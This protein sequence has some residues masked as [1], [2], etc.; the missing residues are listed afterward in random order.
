MDDVFTAAEVGRMRQAMLLGTA[1]VTIPMPAALTATLAGSETETGLALLVLV[2]QRQRFE[3]PQTATAEVVEAATRLHQ[4]PLPILPENA[5]RLFRRL[6]TSVEK[7]LAGGVV[8]AARRRL[9]L[10]GY[11]PHPFDLPS[12]VA[13]LDATADVLTLSERAYLA[14]IETRPETSAPRL[15]DEEITA[16]TWLEFPKAQRRTF[17]RK[18]RA[19]D[20][21]AGRLL[22]EQC[23]A[24][25]QAAMRSELLA[26][27]ATG[28]GTADV[29]FL[30]SLAKDRAES[31][32]SIATRL[33]SQVRGNAAHSTRL[34]EAAKCFERS[35]KLKSA[36]AK[37]GLADAG[38]NFA[39][40]KAGSARERATALERLFD[41]IGL[42]DLVSA[43]GTDSAA[44]L[45][46][47]PAD[48]VVA[49]HLLATARAASDAETVRCIAEHRVGAAAA[50]D[51]LG[52]HELF[53]I[54]Q[55][56][57]GPLSQACGAHVLASPGLAKAMAV[58]NANAERPQLKDDG[59]LVLTATLMPNELMRTFLAMLSP[60][61]PSA[62]RSAHDFAELALCL[63]GP[64]APETQAKASR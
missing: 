24:N 39:A 53:E 4:D 56:L 5:R 10:A 13:H 16:D 49:D 61:L 20:A 28:L 55:A 19:R 23:W 27:L 17:L 33:L 54:V 26:V 18:L 43:T 52:G 6:L 31:V 2:G 30:E 38:V 29:A 36:L 37:A 7:P 35:G 25:E 8:P 32:R 21:E 3:R 63:A 60:L 42:P 58:F 45:A 64:A 50:H 1:R 11:R 41:G 48:N 62:A 47:L 34:A 51:Y 12:L 14:L 22:L 40:P 44:L 59:T 57:G 9:A 15:F 46:A